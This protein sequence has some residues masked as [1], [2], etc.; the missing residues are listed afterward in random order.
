[1]E[2]CWGFDTLPDPEKYGWENVMYEYH[3]YNLW[4]SLL[5]YDLYYMYQDMLNIG[6]DYDVPTYIG[7]FTVF[8]DKEQWAKELALF[9]KRGYSWTIWS[10]KTTVT[11][12]WTSSWGVYTNQLKF[13]TEREDVKCNVATCTY[14]EFVAA[15]E[16]TRTEN[17]VTATL[18]EVLQEYKK[19]RKEK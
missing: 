6:R 19:T 4:S 17:C 9:D 18:Y 16:T 1:M 7:E 12:W 13:W 3:W 5:P 2:G 15:C 11:G 14:E 8:E 10:Y